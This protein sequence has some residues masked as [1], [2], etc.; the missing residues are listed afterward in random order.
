MS[1]VPIQW[2]LTTLWS[3]HEMQWRITGSDSKDCVAEY[4]ILWEYLW[5]I[6]EVTC[7]YWK[8]VPNYLSI[9]STSNFKSI[10]DTSCFN[11]SQLKFYPTSI[12]SFPHVAQAMWDL[13][14]R[15]Y[16]P[17]YPTSIYSFPHVVRLN[18]ELSTGVERFGYYISHLLQLCLF[19]TE[20]AVLQLWTRPIDM[21]SNTQCGSYT[22]IILRQK[23]SYI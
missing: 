11:F 10:F 23:T 2:I 6:I 21:C 19:C 5:L 17:F 20:K 14:H 22:H 18:L 9:S 12:Y 3:W 15:L 7:R 1:A 4:L 13:L 16:C 8:N